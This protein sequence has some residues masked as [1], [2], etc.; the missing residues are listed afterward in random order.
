MATTH[1]RAATAEYRIWQ[2][3]KGR[4]GNP[5]DPSY[6]DYGGRGITVCDRWLSGFEAFFED[7]G[8][9][10]SPRHSIDRIDN[11]KGYDPSNC[12][13]ATDKE[14]ASNRRPK[15]IAGEK[16]PRA[17]LTWQQVR[18]IRGLRGQLS[19][20][21]IARRFDVGGSTVDAILSG[22]HWREPTEGV[23]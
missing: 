3:V 16:N 6:P 12:R 18:E 21:K 15:D 19:T 8:L 7:M 13:W 2:H 11:D 14:Q 22:L 17:R 9:R 10:P 5:R 4:C 1:G 20:R 23:S